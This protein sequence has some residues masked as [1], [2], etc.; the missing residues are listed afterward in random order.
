LLRLP[1]AR[2]AGLP[3]WPGRKVMVNVSVFALKL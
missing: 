2:P 3:L 1:A